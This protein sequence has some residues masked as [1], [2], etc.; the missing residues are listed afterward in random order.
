MTVV[1]H[2]NVEVVAMDGFTGSRPQLLDTF[3]DSIDI[4]GRRLIHELEALGH[5]KRDSASARASPCIEA[6]VDDDEPTP[7][8][9]PAKDIS[10]A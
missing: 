7:V 8:N 2:R 5:A 1:V 6:V 10:K 4:R 9:L 3:A